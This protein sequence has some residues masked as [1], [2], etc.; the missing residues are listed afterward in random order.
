VNNQISFTKM[1][2]TYQ[3]DNKNQ[4]LAQLAYSLIPINQWVL[5]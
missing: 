5:A 2:N 1:R 3:F 4:C